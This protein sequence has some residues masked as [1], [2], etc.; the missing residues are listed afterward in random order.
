M[1]K[2]IIPEDSPH[3]ASEPSALLQT[4]TIV[5]HM[6]IYS[7]NLDEGMFDSD[8]APCQYSLEKAASLIEQSEEEYS[9][10]NIYSTSEAINILRNLC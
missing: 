9:H 6:P 1:S 8:D 3:M 2:Y 7:D 5:S 10:G 4:D